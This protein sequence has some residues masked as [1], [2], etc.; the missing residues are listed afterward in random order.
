MCYTDGGVI[1]GD[2]LKL[3]SAGKHFI[4]LLIT[5]T[6]IQNVCIT[7]YR[8]IPIQTFNLTYPPFEFQFCKM[9][10]ARLH[11]SQRILMLQ[12]FKH[13]TEPYAV[14]LPYISTYPLAKCR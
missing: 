14:Y 7:N 5:Q 12:I 4:L 8:S 3:L 6:D 10:Q 9:S 13:N 11:E 2:I 1:I